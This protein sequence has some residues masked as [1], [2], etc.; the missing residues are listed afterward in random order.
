ME[1]K[2]EERKAE[3]NVKFIFFPFF[4]LFFGFLD[5]NENNRFD[6]RNYFNISVFLKC[7]VLLKE[8]VI[9]N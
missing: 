8:K 9:Y 3:Q 1:R 5:V 6:S 7:F 2:R 4:H